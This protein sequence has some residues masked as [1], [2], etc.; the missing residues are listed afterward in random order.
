MRSWHLVVVFLSRICSLS[1]FWR[2]MFL[3]G[4]RALDL[5]WLS[6]SALQWAL[7]G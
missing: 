7:L 3:L 5:L 2:V 1:V 4:S 6:L